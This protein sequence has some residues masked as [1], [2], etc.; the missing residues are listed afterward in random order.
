LRCRRWRRR[1]GL[2]A[3]LAACYG[4]GLL[5]MKWMSAP[6]VSGLAEVAKQAPEPAPQVALRPSAPAEHPA[7]EPVPSPLALEWQALDS[8]EKRP[9]LFRAAGDRYLEEAGDVQ[10]AMRCYKN[11][12]DVSSNEEAAVSANDNW[13]LMALKEAKQ[14]ENRDARSGS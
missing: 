5:T 7:R 2:A 4:A 10:S 12:L 9:E 3:A 8:K 13:L 1:V 6:P 14:R 11:Y